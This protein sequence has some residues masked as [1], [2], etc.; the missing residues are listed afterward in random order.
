MVTLFVVFTAIL[1][2]LVAVILRTYFN[3]AV[4]E[5]LPADQLHKLRM[6]GLVIKATGIVVSISSIRTCIYA[7]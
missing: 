2:V 5:G 6:L 7:F 3:Q 1:A 4:P